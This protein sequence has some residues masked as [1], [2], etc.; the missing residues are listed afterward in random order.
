MKALLQ[1]IADNIQNTYQFFKG[2]PLRQGDENVTQSVKAGALEVIFAGLARGYP[3]DSSK[4]FNFY[5]QGIGA[6]KGAVWSMGVA[7]DKNVI[8]QLQD[9][10]FG[11]A[12][13]IVSE[14]SAGPLSTE[15][16]AME[17]KENPVIYNVPKDKPLIIPASALIP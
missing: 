6:D 12:F 1:K 14:K 17:T 2:A 3:T 9:L 4:V 11:E 16:V 13:N 7:K 5:L 10:K 15:I 8:A